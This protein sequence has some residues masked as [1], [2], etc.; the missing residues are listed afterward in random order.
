MVNDGQ[1]STTA[2]SYAPLPDSVAAKVKE[3]VKQVK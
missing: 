3:T 1:K 2:L